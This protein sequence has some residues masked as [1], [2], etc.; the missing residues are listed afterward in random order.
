MSVKAETRQPRCEVA[1]LLLSKRNEILIRYSA[2]MHTRGQYRDK[3]GVE[4]NVR[5]VIKPRFSGNMAGGRFCE[6]EG[7]DDA[8]FFFTEYR[9]IDVVH[10][11]QQK[12]RNRSFQTAYHIRPKCQTISDRIARRACSSRTSR[13]REF[14]VERVPEMRALRVFRHDSLRLYVKFVSG[15]SPRNDTM[16]ENSLRYFYI[17]TLHKGDMK[18]RVHST[19]VR[20]KPIYMS[21]VM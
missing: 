5:N 21:P 20:V 16:K 11:F 8:S 19:S 3:R 18:R 10:R 17:I 7:P 13:S 2:I 9:M 15:R 4:S 6:N 1:Y 12:S 14:G